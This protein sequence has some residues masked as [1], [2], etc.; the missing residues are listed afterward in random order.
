MAVRVLVVDDEPA[1][2]SLVARALRDDGHDV[3]TVENGQM[4]YN[5]A[6]DERFDVVVTNNC[7]PGMDGAGLVRALRR[8]FPDLPII[9]LD[10]GSLG[11]RREIPSDVVTIPKP[12]DLSAVRSAVRALLPE[13]T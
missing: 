11:N 12:F 5:T 1:V 3:V 2:R 9:Q 6:L 4:A 13:S 7:M 8:H 10:D